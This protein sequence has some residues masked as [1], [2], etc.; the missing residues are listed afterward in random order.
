MTKP[1]AVIFMAA[2]IALAAPRISE[3]QD[4]KAFNPDQVVAGVDMSSVEAAIQKGVEFLKSKN[5]DHLKVC[6][7]HKSNK[8]NIELVLLTYV[9][10]GYVP[11]SDPAFR[12]LF[13]EMMKRPLEATYCV[14]LQAMVL[15]EMNRVKHQSRIWQ[16]AQF[17]VDNQ[18]ANGQWSYGESTPAVQGVPTG[19]T[20]SA[21]S[22]GPGGGVKIYDLGV[23]EK[24]K[25]LKKLSVSRTRMGPATGDN[26]NSQYAALG[27]RACHDAGITIPRD[28][29][30]LAM[31]WWKESQKDKPD[32]GDK[33]R[34]AVSTGW[35]DLGP[36]RG[37]CYNDHDHK[38]YGSM[39][40][41]AVGALVIYNYML[42]QN[43]SRDSS[44]RSGLSWLVNNF[45]VT[46]N[47]GDVCT[48]GKKNSTHYHY[49]MYALERVGMLYGTAKIGG[50]AWYAEGARELLNRQEGNGCW[51][52][53]DGS[54]V[55]WDTCFAILFLKR[56]TRPL[57]ASQD[58]RRKM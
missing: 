12:Q 16:C 26:S 34:E 50:H 2:G 25:P 33:G 43:W 36:P 32:K 46:Q 47:P 17:L 11:E 31:K 20:P 54:N 14:S 19:G 35:V 52:G 10:S 8:T 37:W 9:H 15:E 6:H 24:P 56:A 38:A 18:C 53:S 39:T 40:A 45:S 7:S 55:V 42:E 44:V 29:I 23:R 5:S 21:V 30:S 58:V 13:D 3:A 27:L 57:V 41:G 51:K 49:Y 22:T 48:F 28:V 4:P 1:G